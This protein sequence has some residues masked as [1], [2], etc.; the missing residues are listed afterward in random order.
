ME[1][2]H[3]EA[4]WMLLGDGRDGSID[5]V[6]RALA[7]AH[8]L[9]ADDSAVASDLA[10]ASIVR[11]QRHNEAR[12]F[13]A[14]VAYSERA[15]QLD[16]SREEARFNLALALEHL[17]L[18]I[19][20]RD[21]WSDYLAKTEAASPWAQ[22]ARERRAALESTP[23]AVKWQTVRKALAA[24]PL[25]LTGPATRRAIDGLAQQARL[26][27]EDEVMPAWAAAEE[28]NETAVAT[29]EIRRATLIAG[30]LA[31]ETGDLLL[32]D[33]IARV[34]ERMHAAPAVRRHLIQGHLL[35]S[36]GRYLY[37]QQNH[38]E[39]KPLLERARTELAAAASPFALWAEYY[40]AVC[41]YHR[42][43][44]S[45][46]LR[47]LTSLIARLRDSPYTVLRAHAEWMAG[48]TLLD[49]ARYGEAVLAFQRALEGF[50]SAREPEN[51][52][53]MHNLLSR[54]F[55]AMGDDA[56]AWSHRYSALRGLPQVAKDR[57][58]SN[59]LSSA[60]DGAAA[61]GFLTVADRFQREMVRQ[62]R[63]S[64]NALLATIALHKAASLAARLGR[65]DEARKRLE[66][67]KRWCVLVA[68]SG[69]RARVTADLLMAEG[70]VS[71]ESAPAAS[72]A[73]LERALALF[74]EQDA[75]VRL[76][77]AERHRAGTLAVARDTAGAAD[78]YRNAIAEAE[79]QI[80]GVPQSELLAYANEMRRLYDEFIVLAA[81]QLGP[82][83]LFLWCERARTSYLRAALRSL[84]PRERFAETELLSTLSADLSLD[85]L[86][87]ELP[88]GTL[89]VQYKL[90][91]DRLLR[92]SVTAE[93]VG[94]R[95]T[96]IDPAALA[97]AV[98]RL[99][100]RV[101]QGATLAALR[102]SLSLIG[103]L[104]LG[105]IQELANTR[106]LVVVPDGPLAA[107]PFDLLF[108]PGH[109]RPLVEDLSVVSLPSAS[110]LS[111]SSARQAELAHHTPQT[112]LALGDP[113][114]DRRLFASFGALPDARAEAEGVGSAYRWSTVLLGEAAT[115]EALERLGPANDVIHIASHAV[116]NARDP[117]RSS[118]L[119]AQDRLAGDHG[120]LGIADLRRLRLPRTQL[121]V[122]AGCDTAAGDSAV[123]DGIPVFLVP[124]L[125]VGV[126]ML[127]ASLW[128]VDD[129]ASSV[130]VREFHRRVAA[131]ES[132]TTALRAAK[133]QLLHATE[134]SLMAPRV[135]AP[136]ILVGG[137]P[138]MADRTERRVACTRCG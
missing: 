49:Q 138:P 83:E 12:D 1:R 94:F 11:A 130:V 90:L 47:E 33:A 95:Q 113:A 4:V 86:R 120:V 116:V 50:G 52:A 66:E 24:E 32:R 34:A 42:P 118:V 82:E 73:A 75:R 69:A 40:S 101:R 98:G 103:E 112:V 77:T 111:A 9:A 48:L 74:R 87:A 6:V 51:A 23:I 72:L 65:H 62:A 46:A 108:A 53:A 3:V 80:S 85:A 99:R 128:E 8:R 17:H 14:A 36:K 38:D 129:A 81:K 93:G 31:A 21:A 122:L 37:E 45:A 78:A 135:W 63:I 60:V 27:L 104:V 61:A 58:V 2:L 44:Y 105:E 100:E 117:W 132:P 29:L 124:L 22:E 79:A 18:A 70:E 133:L 57:R 56:T 136:L 106:F 97:S 96:E 114:F 5:R 43:D 26:Y 55:E 16:P 15:L 19:Q 39:A 110:L 107:L 91:P 126:P 30:A 20:A 71:R 109:S 64:G 54:A 68:G 28:A 25:T 92:W 89:L 127:V 137:T 119:L 121:I 102:D 41:D 134:E 67:A 123:S 115:R 10:A 59:I 131:G 88:A 7:K 13:L 76:V 84:E 125:A 35:Y